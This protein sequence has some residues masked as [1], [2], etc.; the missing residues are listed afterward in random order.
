MGVVMSMDKAPNLRQFEREF[1]D[2]IRR[3]HHDE[4]DTPPARVG[5]LYQSLIY[6]NISGFVNQCFPV[7]RQIIERHF[8]AE[9][10]QKL[11]KAFIQSGQMASPYFSEINEQFVAYLSDE[12]LSCFNLPAYLSELA[13][14]E[15]VELYVDNLPNAPNVP[16]L[17]EKGRSIFINPTAQI[18]YYEWAVPNIGVSFLPNDKEPTFVIVYRKYDE[19]YKT[20]F[21][22]INQMSFVILTFMQNKANSGVMYHHIDELFDALKGEF[23]LDETVL[24]MMRSSF[25]GLVETMIDNQVFY[26]EHSC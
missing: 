14:Y 21:M 3:Q 5:R 10:W 18:L 4:T 11:I 12:V 13:H 24:S 17:I 9:V 2:Y 19:Q 8:G 22:H 23:G 7:C 26:V 15:W 25:A 16:C 6:N 20:A 1:G